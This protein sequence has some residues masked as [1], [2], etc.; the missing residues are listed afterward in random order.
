MRVSKSNK[1]CGYVKA[2]QRYRKLEDRL[3]VQDAELRPLRAEVA[4]AGADVR[5][6]RQGMTGGQ[7]GEAERILKG[8][9][10][11]VPEVATA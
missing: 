7:I 4:E 5:E 2:V 3:R 6:R 11:P 1:V 8:Q 10:E 9:P